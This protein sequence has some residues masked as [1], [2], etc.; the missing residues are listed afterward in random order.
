MLF[1]SSCVVACGVVQGLKMR[2]VGKEPANIF[3]A[4]QSSQ[5]RSHLHREKSKF[6]HVRSSC[7]FLRSDRRNHKLSSRTQSRSTSV[8]HITKLPKSLCSGHNLPERQF[9]KTISPQPALNVVK[10]GFSFMSYDVHLIMLILAHLRP[11]ALTFATII[12]LC[13]AS[14][15]MHSDEA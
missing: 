10:H 5:S 8:V 11:L 2:T 3:V 12:I 7:V 6:V 1:G 14:S 15:A 13:Y 4:E 9:P